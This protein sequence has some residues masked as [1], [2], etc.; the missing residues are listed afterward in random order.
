MMHEILKKTPSSILA[1]L[2]RGGMTGAPKWMLIA[3]LLIIPA[4]NRA[5][6]KGD[7]PLSP[8][9]LAMQR[10][11]LKNVEAEDSTIRVDLMY[12]KADN[13]TGEVLYDDLREAYLHPI[14]M[15]ALA[16]AQTL[17]KKQRPDLSLIVFDAARPMSIQQKMWSC[18]RGTD[19][20]V[21]VS[22]PANGGGLHNYGLAVD[23]SLCNAAG[24][25]LPMG[26]RVD[27]MSPLSHIDNE[28]MLVTQGMMSPEALANRRLLRRVM[29]EAGWRALKTEW[30]HFNIRSRAEAR[31]YFKVIE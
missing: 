19:K 21:Y 9:A 5:G 29:R 14:A 30:W 10:M 28:E 25:T 24:D 13:F 15:T 27:T 17:L 7:R 6:G 20:S 23:I 11:G 1:R 18:V 16:K 3:L 26:T 22:N 2:P 4:G 31:Q 12:A 8:T